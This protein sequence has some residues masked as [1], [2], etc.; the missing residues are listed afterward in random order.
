MVHPHLV[1]NEETVF[2]GAL[3]PNVRSIKR[4]LRLDGQNGY[5]K[6]LWLT[7]GNARIM[8]DG[9]TK[10]IGPNTFVFVPSNAPHV[11]E[12]GINTY[13][14]IIAI[15]PN[16][17]I[18]LPIN[19]IIF[20]VLNIMQQ[21]QTTK[22]VDNIIVE[23]SSNDPGQF[24]AM[25]S[26]V[27]LLLIHILRLAGDAIETKKQTA[28]QKLMKKFSRLLENQYHTGRNLNDY[29]EALGVTTTHLSR[30]SREMNNKSASQLI[31]DRVLGEAAQM[32]LYTDMKI[33]QI[34]EKLGFR[35]A[36]YFSRLFTD[37][38]HQGPKNFRNS[39]AR[40]SIELQRVRS[41]G[42]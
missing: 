41:K 36:A 23:A 16:T 3:A 9:N 11:F 29:A 34:S 26:Y 4:E 7:K 32:L 31:Q 17:R 27:K 42:V 6:I 13:G 35:S 38:M 22:F 2:V 25:E 19:P 5:H 28:S 10:G 14:S 18:Q 8:I 37:K 24:M 20:P 33:Q 40:G 30:V 39:G 15:K 1:D 12:V 21:S